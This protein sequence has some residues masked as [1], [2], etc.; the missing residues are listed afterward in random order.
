[1]IR[2]SPPD[3]V[4][5]DVMMPRLD[6]F[7]LLAGAAGLPGDP[8]ATGDHPVGAGRRRGRDRGPRSRRRRLPAQA[9][10][11]PR[12]ARARAR[13]PGALAGTAPVLSGRARRARDARADVDATARGSSAGRSASRTEI[14]LANDQVG[15]I[16]GREGIRPEE[17]RQLIHERLYLSDRNTLLGHPGLLTRAMQNEVIEGLEL[18]FRRDDGRWRTIL[19]S[20]A[21]VRRRGRHRGRRRRSAR[22]HQRAR[23]DPEAACRPARRNGDDRPWRAA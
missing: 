10:L 5:T 16:L 23:A 22:G 1:M 15:V 9:V 3:L 13:A 14:V 19:T 7:G 11:R 2:R 8:G 4:V 18:T 12:A 6:G 21:P 20:A 17:I